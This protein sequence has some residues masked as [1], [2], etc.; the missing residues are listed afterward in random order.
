MTSFK[1]K[2]DLNKVPAHVALIM[3]GN[4]RWA[5]QRNRERVYGHREGVNS[6]KAVVEAAGEIGVRYLT[7]YAFSSENW[8]RPADEVQA[9]MALLVQGIQDELDNIMKQ[10]IRIRVIGDL[11]KLKT[12]VRSA[13]EDSLER[14][15]NNT[16]MDVIIALSYSGRDEKSMQPGK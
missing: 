12:E 14:T 9:L 10:N 2:I 15:K 13:V 16:A 8:A 7:L 3:D 1:D 11:S 5:K 6:V 4:G